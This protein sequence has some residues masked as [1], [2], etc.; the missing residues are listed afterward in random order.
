MAISNEGKIGIV[1]GLLGLGGAG[2]IMV[3]PQ[4]LA[5]G[6][7]LIVIAIA[8]AILLAYHHFGGRFGTGR[9][10]NN[11]RRMIPLIGMVVFGLAFLASAGW[12]FWPSQDHQ[13]SDTEAVAHLAELG[14]AVQPGPAGMV[15]EIKE[16]PLPPMEQSA[17]YF[18]QLRRPFV[19][20]FQLISGIEGLHYL[21]GINNLK[22]L[23]INAGR[24]SDISELRNFS[25]LDSLEISQTPFDSFGILDV[26]PLAS[27][28]NLQKLILGGSKVKDIS[29]LQKLTK[30]VVLNL[31]DTLVSDISS[32]AKFSLLQTFDIRGAPA[33]DMSPLSHCAM[34]NELEVGAPQLPGIEALA[35]LTHLG[36][37]RIIAQTNIDL[38]PV[39]SLSS[40]D[41]LF[42]W[43]PST[44]D[45]LPLQNLRNL[46]RLQISGFMLQGRS[47]VKNVQAL[48]ALTELQSLVMG[49]LQISDL[50]FLG[51]LPHLEILNLGQMPVQSLAPLST[52][53]TL[54]KIS[55]MDVPVVDISPLLK[56]PSLTDV[57][58]MRVPAR[59]DV[60]T[61]LEN[62]GVKIEK[63]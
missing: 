56:L 29:A 17:V 36:K 58:I 49:E 21:A 2:A 43:G 50:S 28:T 7:G 41:D 12:Y 11:R 13:L 60:L 30:L 31:G 15:F 19:L 40:L 48:G 8:G 23:S 4:F 18:K 22:T 37:L 14:W 35:N 1:L 44:L 62:R 16:K 6:W 20:R 46:H 39:W 45:L 24:F 52:I 34:L 10:R 63:H 33:F 26:T 32:V 59:A 25:N 51:A 57:M 5:I 54:K 61:D 55:L 53:P 47:L 27:L 42:I 9:D 3:A 38:S